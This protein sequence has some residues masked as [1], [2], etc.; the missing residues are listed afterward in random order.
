MEQIVKPGT[1]YNDVKKIF[2]IQGFSSCGKDSITTK[3]SKELNLPILTSH[4]SRPMR[5]GEIDGEHYFFTD[6]KFFEENND[7]FLEQRHYNTVYG[8]WKYGLH[9][10]ALTNKPYSL[11]IVDRK[12]FTELSNKLGEDKLISI[13]IEVDEKELKHRQHLRGDCELEFARRLKS[14]KE[15]FNGYISDYI[16]YNNESL[17]IAVQQVKDIIVEE[18]SEE[19]F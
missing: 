19:C 13:F 1:Q 15:E 18:M 11:F 4:T 7:N 2:C 9:Q 12:G 5:D 10:T 17:E 6:D 3:V 16:V 14:D 8:V